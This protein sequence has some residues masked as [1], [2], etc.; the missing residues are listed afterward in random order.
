LCELFN[1]EV[2]KM[3]EQYDIPLEP[4]DQIGKY[5]FV[6]IRLYQLLYQ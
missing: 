6:N 5:V 3:V 4:V 2:K 1:P